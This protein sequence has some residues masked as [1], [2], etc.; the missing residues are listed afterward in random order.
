M[1][2]R[3]DGRLVEKVDNLSDEERRDGDSTSEENR[4]GNE[5]MDRQPPDAKRV[6]LFG[7][8]VHQPH[9]LSGSPAAF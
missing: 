1:H 6:R 3:E 8:H 9:R 4:R 2:Q 5:K 7:A